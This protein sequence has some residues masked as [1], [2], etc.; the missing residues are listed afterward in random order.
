MNADLQGVAP[1]S[2]SLVA[3]LSTAG[4][5]SLIHAT[6]ANKAEEDLAGTPLVRGVDETPEPLWELN[7]MNVNGG[8][9]RVSVYDD[10][11]FAEADVAAEPIA[12]KH[13][14][15]ALRRVCS[16][17]DG[18]DVMLQRKF[19]GRSASIK[20]ASGALLN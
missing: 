11:A 5:R 15:L 10:V 9:A 19:G 1:L 12:A 3:P 16:A 2:T 13:L 8:S 20:I 7:S 18:V 6:R 4:W 17:T 14:D